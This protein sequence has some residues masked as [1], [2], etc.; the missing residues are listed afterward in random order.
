VVD[1]LLGSSPLTSE[2]AHV[3]HTICNSGEAPGS[4]LKYPRQLSAGLHPG[5][6]SCRCSWQRPQRD[7][8][9]W[10]WQQYPSPAASMRRCGAPAASPPRLPRHWGSASQVTSPPVYLTLSGDSQGLF[11]LLCC[12]ISLAL[13]YRWQRKCCTVSSAHRA[14]AR[15]KMSDDMRLGVPGPALR[16]SVL[17]LVFPSLCSHFRWFSVFFSCVEICRCGLHLEVSCAPHLN[18]D[19]VPTHANAT[20]SDTVTRRAVPLPPLKQLTEPSPSSSTFHAL[21]IPSLSGTSGASPEV[22]SAHGQPASLHRQ[23]QGPPAKLPCPLPDAPLPA[24]NGAGSHSHSGVWEEGRQHR[25]RREGPPWTVHTL[26]P[27]R[28]LRL[29]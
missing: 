8:W 5:R 23:P 7:S 24:G 13:P 15:E 21:P 19:T 20:H 26:T 11:H 25:R 1:L 17:L 4:T 27:F 14:W 9:H 10:H 3:R 12:L 22:L 28:W 16:G 6:D 29:Q 2:A 18:S